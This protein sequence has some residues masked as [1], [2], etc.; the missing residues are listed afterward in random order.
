MAPWPEKNFI[1]STCR[2]HLL[3]LESANMELL[4]SQFYFISYL[5]VSSAVCAHGFSNPCRIITGLPRYKASIEA[6]IGLRAGGCDSLLGINLHSQGADVL[7]ALRLSDTR[8][9]SGPNL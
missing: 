2:T 8:P 3:S 7:F 6:V 5:S 4:Y 9:I 1:K